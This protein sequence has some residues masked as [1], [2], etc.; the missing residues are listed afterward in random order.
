MTKLWQI[1]VVILALFLSTLATFAA[2]VDPNTTFRVINVSANDADG[3]N[4]R[5][6]PADASNLSNTKIVGHLNWQ[7]TGIITS[8]LVVRFPGA[9]WREIRLGNVI[10]WVN[11]KYLKAEISQQDGDQLPE[12]LLCSGTEPFWGLRISKS[13]S[14][15]D[16]LIGDA[17][18]WLEGEKLDLL[19]RNPFAN[20]ST[21]SWAVTLKRTSASQYIT[22]LI[23]KTDTYCSDGMSDRDYPYQA[24][25]LS[26]NVP[27]PMQGCCQ[28]DIGR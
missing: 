26:G 16:G 4:V 10:G 25:L 23:S 12:K 11:G 6:F 9:I 28:R 17:D 5:D 24:I 15:Y 13:S 21:P 20:R 8:G 27:V 7:A 1:S 22:I 3:L 18:Q 19:A 2:P 14:N